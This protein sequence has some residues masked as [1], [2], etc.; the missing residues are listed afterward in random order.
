MIEPVESRVLTDKNT[1][2]FIVLSTFDACCTI[3]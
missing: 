2:D 3:Q 1:M